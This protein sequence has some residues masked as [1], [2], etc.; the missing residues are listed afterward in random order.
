VINDIDVSVEHQI[1][2]VLRITANL[3]NVNDVFV[4]QLQVRV[5]EKLA[6]VPVKQQRINLYMNVVKNLMS[7]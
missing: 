1:H 6:V 7:G 5:K 4:R 2:T 3:I